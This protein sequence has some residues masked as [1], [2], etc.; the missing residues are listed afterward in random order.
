MDLSSIR[1]RKYEETDNIEDMKIKNP[2]R[3]FKVLKLTEQNELY[4]VSFKEQVSRIRE[5][6][7]GENKALSDQ[8]LSKFLSKKTVN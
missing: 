7:S 2:N 1:I 4:I 3:I 8:E 5:I 6:L